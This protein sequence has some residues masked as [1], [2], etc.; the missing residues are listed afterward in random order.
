MLEKYDLSLCTNKLC[1]KKQ[2]G[3]SIQ[4]M[5]GNVRYKIKDY[6]MHAHNSLHIYR[7]IV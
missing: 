5:Y 6:L 1:R 3:A 4:A 2:S 7:L